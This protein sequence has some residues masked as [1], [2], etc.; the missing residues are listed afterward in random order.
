MLTALVDGPAY[1]DGRA[2][3][4]YSWG[5]TLREGARHRLCPR[6]AH[7]SLALDMSLRLR[8]CIAADLVGCHAVEMCCIFT[9]FLRTVVTQR[10]R[11][12]PG[13][14]ASCLNTAG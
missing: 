5:M 14:P 10:A 11:L 8:C 12:K 6:L 2:A 1:V 3:D 4:T 7:A 9:I 13:R